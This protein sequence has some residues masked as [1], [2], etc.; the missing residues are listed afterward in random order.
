M[1]KNQC[2]QCGRV[3]TAP[4]SMRGQEVPCQNCG[5]L[6]VM[7]ATADQLQQISSREKLKLG[8]A[9]S[10][11]LASVK[12]LYDLSDLL[13]L[14]A[15]VIVSLL[16]LAGAAPLV[17]GQGTTEFQVFCFIGGAVSGVFMFVTFKFLSGLLG[18]VSQQL[19]GQIV[20]QEQLKDILMLLRDEQVP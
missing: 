14:F 12:S 11:Q 17:L 10:E 2:V 8:P 15:Y 6:N 20:V 13:L 9:M 19:A 4:A 18:A 3:I 1:L 7:V 5:S 16:F